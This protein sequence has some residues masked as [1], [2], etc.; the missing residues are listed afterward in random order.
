MK[1]LRRGE[2]HGI[3]VHF[4]FYVSPFQFPA[5]PEDGVDV[6]AESA[7]EHGAAQ[8]RLP[9]SDVPPALRPHHLLLQQVWLLLQPAAGAAHAH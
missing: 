3:E 7:A 1:F 9:E 8:D 6:Q 4:A 5:E 2:I